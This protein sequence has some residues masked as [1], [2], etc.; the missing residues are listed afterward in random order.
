MQC[1]VDK[2]LEW[3][4]SLGSGGEFMSISNVRSNPCFYCCTY[5]DLLKSLGVKPKSLYIFL[6]TTHEVWAWP[7]KS[8]S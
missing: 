5:Q 8:E 2:A 6:Q 7:S 1:G 3:I 4:A